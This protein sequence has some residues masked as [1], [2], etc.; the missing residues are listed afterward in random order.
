VIGARGFD[1]YR[2]HGTARR[3][4]VLLAVYTWRMR[5][6]VVP[7]LSEVCHRTAALVDGWIGLAKQW[8][9]LLSEEVYFAL[10]FT[11]ALRPFCSLKS[12]QESGD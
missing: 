10:F 4:C 7:V 5:S 12:V 3:P 9:P 1:A 11:S 8:D 2:E 6:S